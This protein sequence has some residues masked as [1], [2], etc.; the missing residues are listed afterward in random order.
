MKYSPTLALEICQGIES[1]KQ[2]GASYGRFYGLDEKEIGLWLA[3]YRLYGAAVFYHHPSYT[4]EERVNIVSDKLQNGPT[5]T[6]TCLKYKIL[7]RSSLRNWIRLHKDGRL[8]PMSEKKKDKKRNAKPGDSSQKRIRE[9]ER[10]LLYARAENAYLKKLQALMQ[11]TK[12][13]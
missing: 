12:S 6:Q 2:S 13:H 1:G 7:H 5:I 9:L 11:A 8:E 3:H 10:E 4:L